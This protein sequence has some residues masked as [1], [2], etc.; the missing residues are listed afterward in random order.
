M[1]AWL[2]L[3]SVGQGVGGWR[4]EEFFAN[5]EIE[6]QLQNDGLVVLIWC[7]SEGGWRSEEFFANEEIEVVTK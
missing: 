1:M 3:F 6:V 5:E 2:F 4:S 7:G